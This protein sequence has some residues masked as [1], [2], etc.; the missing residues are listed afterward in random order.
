MVYGKAQ[1][2]VKKNQFG[3]VCKYDKSKAVYSETSKSISERRSPDE[4][5]FLGKCVSPSKHPIMRLS[6]RRLTSRPPLLL[7]EKTFLDSKF[8]F[9]IWKPLFV[10]I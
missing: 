3:K 9:I 8:F 10:I 2:G 1:F 5:S 6:T 7:K 4:K